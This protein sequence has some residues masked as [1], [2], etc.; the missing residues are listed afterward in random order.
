[1]LRLAI[2]SMARVAE[3]TRTAN[4]KP[5]STRINRGRVEA[6]NVAQRLVGLPSAW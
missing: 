6:E 2:I 4:L 3:H 1:M 5:R